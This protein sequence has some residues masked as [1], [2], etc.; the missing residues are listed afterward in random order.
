VKNSSCG[1][2]TSNTHKLIDA[3]AR[4]K[5][6]VKSEQYLTMMLGVLPTMFMAD[7]DHAL[8]LRRNDLLN[9][10]YQNTIKLLTEMVH[11]RLTASIFRKRSKSS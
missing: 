1:Q 10:N 9:M 11:R 6:D 8:T 2:S 4:E 3:L 7:I 5:A